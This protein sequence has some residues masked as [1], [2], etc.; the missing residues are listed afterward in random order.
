MKLSD[1]PNHNDTSQLTIS[2]K[3]SIVTPI[4]Q[5]PEPPAP[6]LKCH[7][8]NSAYTIDLRREGWYRVTSLRRDRRS[9]TY[10]S[11]FI[12]GTYNSLTSLVYGHL[13]KI[14]F[15]LS[16]KAFNKLL[17]NIRNDYLEMEIHFA[18][19]NAQE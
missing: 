16:D 19:S 3:A 1:D 13:E 6:T 4:N 2:P 11:I 14:A 15:L 8:T 9:K 5:T 7:Y 18:K 10:P 17:N 12:Q